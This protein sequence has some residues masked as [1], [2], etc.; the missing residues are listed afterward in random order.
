MHQ[1]TAADFASLP[2]RALEELGVK[3]V[4]FGEPHVW[5]IT[6]SSKPWISAWAIQDA[7]TMLIGMV[8]DRCDLLCVE[9]KSAD[10]KGDEGWNAGV[11]LPGWNGSYSSATYADGETP[12]AAAMA[13]YAAALKEQTTNAPPADPQQDAGVRKDAP[14]AGGAHEPKE[15]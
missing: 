9:P 1:Y 2:P 4:T 13:A 15:T 7:A 6:P 5:I 14:S 12:L 3:L 10:K 11:A 8:Q